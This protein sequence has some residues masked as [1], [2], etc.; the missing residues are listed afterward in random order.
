M[1]RALGTEKGITDVSCIGRL[2]NLFC[3]SR[4][5]KRSAWAVWNVFP[6]LTQ[7]LIDLSTAQLTLEEALQTIERF[8]IL[9]DKRT[10]TA[11]LS[12]Q[13]A[14]KCSQR[15]IMF[16]WFPQHE[17][18]LGE[19]SKELSTRAG[20]SGVRLWYLYQHCLHQLSGAG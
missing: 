8:I 4:H 10:S 7:T 11:T 2:S 1:A 3:F 5:I 20:M 18:P 17:E 15:K 9:L 12:T 16:S 13:L 6:Q 14:G 19:I